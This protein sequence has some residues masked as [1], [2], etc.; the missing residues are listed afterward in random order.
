MAST[1][2]L[3]SEKFPTHVVEFWK[4]SGSVEEMTPDAQSETSKKIYELEIGGKTFEVETHSPETLIEIAL[5]LAEL[6]GLKP[7]ANSEVMIET[8]IGKGAESPTKDGGARGAPMAHVAKKQTFKVRV[9]KSTYE[10]LVPDKQPV[11]E[12]VAQMPE[13]QDGCP[14]PR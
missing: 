11:G 1:V 4:S 8:P 3:M 13:M 6:Y 10:V 2:Y 5:H 9:N 7:D 14:A 12:S